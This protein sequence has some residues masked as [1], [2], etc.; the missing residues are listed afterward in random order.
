MYVIIKNII[1]VLILITFSSSYVNLLEEQGCTKEDKIKFFKKTINKLISKGVDSTFLIRIISDNRVKFDEKYVKIN[2]TSILQKSDYSG[3]YN[4]YSINKVKRFIEKNK[5]MFAECSKYFDIPQEVIG[6]ILWIE[7]KNGTYLGFD[8]IVSVFLSA[9]MSEE[10]QFIQMNY[11]TFRASKEFEDKDS[12]FILN[13]VK[14]RAS[15]KANWALEE[16]IALEQM[17]KKYSID[18]LNLNGSWAGAFGYSQ[19]LPSSFIKYSV[20]GDKDG[21]INLFSLK[22]AIFS[23]ANY[24]KQHGW[25]DEYEAQSQAVFSYNNSKEYVDAVL[26]LYR[27]LV[28]YDTA[29]YFISPEKIPTDSL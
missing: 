9:S 20:D 7:T 4:Q 6:S 2:V 12:A 24:L 26:T 19:F 5:E 25:S 18:I 23:I 1:I 17:Y 27:K 15:K 13:Y 14:A 22:D 21:I 28:S 10:P 3:N 8:H 29:S 11:E 16:L